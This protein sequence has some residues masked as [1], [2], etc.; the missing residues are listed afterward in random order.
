MMDFWS[1]E[2]LNCLK[3]KIW[4]LVLQ[5]MAELLFI[6]FQWEVCENMW[7]AVR[8]KMILLRH[9]YSQNLT[10]GT[11]LFEL[12]TKVNLLISFFSKMD[13][14]RKWE[15]VTILLQTLC[16]VCN[17]NQFILF[18]LKIKTSCFCK[19]GSFSSF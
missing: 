9:I 13:V 6:F 14:L 10:R 16:N 3:K 18:S 19:H 7:H 11:K 17:K 12:N 4:K 15:Q 8:F 5:E 1:E 2:T